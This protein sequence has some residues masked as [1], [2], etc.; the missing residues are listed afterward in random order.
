MEVTIYG[1]TNC[2]NCLNVTRYLETKEIK[3]EYKL[4]GRDL[5]KEDLEDI[6]HH[7]VRTVPVILVDGEEQTFDELRKL[8]NKNVP[9]IPLQNLKL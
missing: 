5:S 6:V 9:Q 4:V 7:S 1:K 2:S 8:T 3:H